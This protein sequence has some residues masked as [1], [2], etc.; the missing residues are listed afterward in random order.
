MSRWVG[1]CVEP[2]CSWRC[3]RCAVLTCEVG[4]AICDGRERH[5]VEVA[6]RGGL[7]IGE[8]AEEDEQRH[9]VKQRC[10]SLKA[11]KRSHV[12]GRDEWKR[13]GQGEAV[14]QAVVALLGEWSRV[15]QEAVESGAVADL[16][17]SRWE[18]VAMNYAALVLCR[19]QGASGELL[20]SR[21]AQLA[22]PSLDWLQRCRPLRSRSYAR[23]HSPS[24]PFTLRYTCG[25]AQHCV[26]LS[27]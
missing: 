4:R 22:Q 27:S 16:L 3:V 24:L 20:R 6:A 15:D 17:S 2:G 19:R 13:G 11:V 8:L 10:Q 1:G 7:A 18:M 23:I 26:A 25:R 5:S 12:A 9:Q 14:V 21:L